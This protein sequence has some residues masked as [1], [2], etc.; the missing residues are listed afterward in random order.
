MQEWVCGVTRELVSYGGE[1]RDVLQN[2]G[3]KRYKLVHCWPEQFEADLLPLSWVAEKR[4]IVTE[5]SGGDKGGLRVR[6]GVM[7]CVEGVL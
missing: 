6:T 5:Q 3:D 7:R 1:C 4:G 2:S